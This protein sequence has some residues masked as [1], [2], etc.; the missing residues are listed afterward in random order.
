MRIKM[1]LYTAKCVPMCFGFIYETK[2]HWYMYDPK[3]FSDKHIVMSTLTLDFFWVIH[4]PMCFGFIDKTIFFILFNQTQCLQQNKLKVIFDTKTRNEGDINID[5]LFHFQRYNFSSLR[6]VTLLIVL[7][8]F[9]IS[10]S[11]LLLVF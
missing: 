5:P 6:I 9:C 2:A 10:Y 4:V 3:E 7:L 11:P 8:Y 1:S